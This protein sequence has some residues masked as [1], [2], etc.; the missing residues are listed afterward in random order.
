MIETLRCLE[1]TIMENT[2]TPR[3]RN[4]SGE[5]KME[6]LFSVT[7]ETLLEAAGLCSAPGTH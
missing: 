2:K 7:M 6:L 1:N 5:T 4:P 3:W